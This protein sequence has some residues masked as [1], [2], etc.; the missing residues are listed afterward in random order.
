M[1]RSNSPLS[2][3]RGLFTLIELL[4]VIAIIAILAAMLMPALQQARDRAKGIS[5]VNRQK[6]LSFPLNQYSSDYDGFAVPIAG[7]DDTIEVWSEV[8]WKYG[9]MTNKATSDQSYR[10]MA[11]RELRCPG[12]VNA[13][14]GNKTSDDLSLRA[15]IYGMIQWGSSAITRYPFLYKMPHS[16]DGDAYGMVVKKVRRPSTTGWILDS[17]KAGTRR[18]W[19][20]I[21]CGKS[22][23]A[24][25]LDPAT[26]SVAGAAPAHNGRTNMLMVSGNVVTWSPADFAKIG[27]RDW[28]KDG[29]D[30]CNVRYYSTL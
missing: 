1:K 2:N 16:Y 26:S 23:S 15:G 22:V 7:I 21:D 4:V 9:Y 18:Q 8:L 5:C 19:F 27:N 28:E 12:L 6:Q 17:W 25:P 13:I 14:T 20:R 10:T 11:D 3:A 29:Y 24:T 30:F